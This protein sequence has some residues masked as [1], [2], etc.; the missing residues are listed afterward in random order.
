MRAL[1]DALSSL[2]APMLLRPLG[3]SSEP[4]AAIARWR[5]GPTTVDVPASDAIRLVMTL[6]DGRDVRRPGGGALGDRAQAGSISVFMPAERVRVPIGGDA[7]VV[8][9]FVRQDFAEALL[10]SPFEHVPVFGLRDFGMQAM[11]ARIL[12]GTVGRGFGDRPMADEALLALL[13]RV[14]D[15]AAERRLS[16]RPPPSRRKGGMPPAA[17]RRVE[18][19]IEAALENAASPTL[20]NLA[21]VARSSVTH[22]ARSFRQQTGISPHRHLIR[23]RIEHATS[24]LRCADLAVADIADRVGF[25]SPAHFV[26]TYRATMGVTPGAVRAALAASSSAG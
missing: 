15:H 4:A 17:L 21:A 14:R 1:D 18:E 23:R 19:A 3:G 2:G 20:A 9:L 7:D 8:Q 16:V 25:S 6:V 24:L 22:F 26:A 11:V 10:G 5:H 12:V 13:R